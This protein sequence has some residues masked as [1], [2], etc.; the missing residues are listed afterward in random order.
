MVSFDDRYA[1]P[2]MA[3]DS[4]TSLAPAL[5]RADGYIRNRNGRG[6]DYTGWI[7]L[8]IDYDREELARI[9]A[10]AESIRADSDVFIVVGIGGSYLG[11]R[12]AIEFLRSPNYN[13]LSKTTPDIYFTGNSF[14]GDDLAEVF[15]L[16]AGKRVSV[17]V[18]SKSGTTTESALAFRFIRRYLSD[19]YSEDEIKKR[20]FCTCDRARGALKSFADAEG[21]QTFV[22]PDDIG[23]RFSVLTA[24]GLLPIAVAGCDIDALLQGA[25]DMRA[26]CFA[27]GTDNPAYR[28]A[29][30][31]NALYASGKRV[32][33]LASYESSFRMM[34]EWWKQLF[35]ESEGK[36]QK[37]IFPSSVS[38]STDLHSLGQFI[39][40]GSRIM[41][42]TV[43]K[44]ESPRKDMEVP[45]DPEN[46]DGLNYLAG[47]TMNDINMTA[48][49]GTMLAHIDGGVP[50][51]TVTYDRRC[52]HTLGELIYFFELACAAS[53]YILGINPFDQPGVED[54]KRNMFALLGKPGYEEYGTELKNRMN[55]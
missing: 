43:V 35:G 8:P 2:F 55:L 22:I 38:L 19:R 37:G 16:C 46:T 29:V 1:R 4:L 6:S 11:A 32:E 54:Y 28:Y 45:F 7:D 34:A 41:F 50:N 5:A 3:D 12:A 10:A 39:Q 24:V 18:V 47:R 17:N 36:E 40:D 51:L 15:E 52:E 9:K 23:G 53:G 27:E 25:A 33:I 42:E 21:L 49:T 13:S 48:M 44:Q 20:V 30:A 31:R 26:A 14:S